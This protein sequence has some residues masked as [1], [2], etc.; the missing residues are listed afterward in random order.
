ML[1]P[2]EDEDD[3]CLFNK[4]PLVSVV[5]V[6]HE[7]FEISDWFNFKFIKQV[8]SLSLS[9]A[10]LNKMKLN[11]VIIEVWMSNNAELKHRKREVVF[12]HLLR[13]FILHSCV[14]AAFTSLRN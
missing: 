3:N 5:E 13:D 4:N 14:T 8:H 6:I 12:Y 9:A 1:H 2:D 10:L 11:Y 7:N